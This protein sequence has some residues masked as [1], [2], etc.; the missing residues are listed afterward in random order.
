MKTAGPKFY[1][2]CGNAAYNRGDRGNLKTQLEMLRQAYPTA[3]ITLDSFAPEQDQ[4]W[5]DAT[6]LKRGTV[7]SK[8]QRRAMREADVIIWGGGALLADNACRTLVPYWCLM[9][10]YTKFILRK[11]IC[12]WAHGVVLE[13]RT[14][15]FFAKIALRC[16]D[17]ITVRDQNSFQTIEGLKVKNLKMRQTA[18]PAVALTAAGR[19]EGEKIL[20]ETGADGSK[21]IIGFSLTFWHLFYQAKDLIPYFMGRKWGL[22]ANRNRE[23]CETYLQGAAALI[24]ELL[25]RRDCQI[26]LIPRYPCPPWADVPLLESIVR[27]TPP[28]KVF[29]LKR[30]DYPPGLYFSI[31]KRLDLLISVALHDAIFSLS[32]GRPAIGLPYEPKGW[33]F[34]EAAG[35]KKFARDWRTLFSN[36]G[37]NEIADLSLELLENWSSLAPD[38]MQNMAGLQK[39]AR[40]NL[41]ELDETLHL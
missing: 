13:T 25:D 24:Q 34:F 17:R 15:K 30:D 35:M 22:Y 18:D 3:Q 11:K 36:P 29:I 14:G 33:D 40:S 5:F 4:Q 1:I 8:T 12:A 38:V 41:T 21:K 16:V 19:D 32:Q 9:I 10:F 20:A 7:P 39:S 27:R 31:F 23:L 2:L 6:V 26:V 37:R 28:Q